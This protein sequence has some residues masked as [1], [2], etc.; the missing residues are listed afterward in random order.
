M[1]SSPLAFEAHWKAH[2]KGKT[3]A[4]AKKRYAKYLKRREAATGGSSDASS[5]V[6]PATQTD[7][8]EMEAW[9]DGD[10]DKPE[11][12]SKI[13]NSVKKELKVPDP[14]IDMDRF[15][16]DETGKRVKYIRSWKK[17]S[18]IGNDGDIRVQIAPKYYNKTGRGL[19]GTSD[20]TISQSLERF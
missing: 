9:I 2:S 5:A 1:A 3:E 17:I 15:V 16:T 18:Q 10:P 20:K 14:N 19:I 4:S 6:T 11:L 8:E 12:L 13:H 7:V